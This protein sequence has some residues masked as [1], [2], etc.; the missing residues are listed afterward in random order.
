VFQTIQQQ[1]I[2]RI[3]VVKPHVNEKRQV[4]LDVQL[5]VTDVLA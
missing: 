5:E 2:V 3:L 1:D 4:T